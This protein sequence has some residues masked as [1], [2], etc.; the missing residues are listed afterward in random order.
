VYAL[1]DL[2]K[3]AVEDVR[4]YLGDDFAD[5]VSAGGVY[6]DRDKLAAIVPTLDR[7]MATTLDQLM[8][9][10]QAAVVARNPAAEDLL[11]I[12]RL[13]ELAAQEEA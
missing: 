11:T 8:S 4:A 5:A 6:M 13:F 3:L 7:G 10:K 12:D 2:E 9:E 1:D